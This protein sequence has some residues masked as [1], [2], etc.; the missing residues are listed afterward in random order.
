MKAK[1]ESE[2]KAVVARAKAEAKRAA[3]AAKDAEKNE[4]DGPAKTLFDLQHC[5]IHPMQSYRKLEDF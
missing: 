2:Q 4:A 1:A 3:K 5:C